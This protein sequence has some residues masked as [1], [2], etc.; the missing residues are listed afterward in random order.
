ML[1]DKIPVRFS[2]VPVVAAASS[3]LKKI[4]ST[5]PGLDFY[6]DYSK[7][8]EDALR[9]LHPFKA[10]KRKVCIVLTPDKVCLYS[11]IGFL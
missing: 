10:P 4:L 8:M 7:Q 6:A 9:Y 3:V 1:S 2:S 5:K 11:M